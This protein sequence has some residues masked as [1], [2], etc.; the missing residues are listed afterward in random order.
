MAPRPFSV[1]MNAP[2]QTTTFRRPFTVPADQWPNAHADLTERG[3][4]LE[5]SEIADLSDDDVRFLARQWNEGQGI[6]FADGAD[7][8]AYIAF[9]RV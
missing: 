8:R 9:L 2:M 6:S 1:I 3:P 5:A 4:R 7:F